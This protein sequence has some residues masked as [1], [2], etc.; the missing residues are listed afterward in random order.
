M[1]SRRS[2]GAGHDSVA[3][4]ARAAACCS[5]S[6]SGTRPVIARQISSA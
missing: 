2:G 1:A 3:S 4:D 5:S 6:A